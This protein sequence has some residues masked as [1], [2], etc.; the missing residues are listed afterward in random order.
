MAFNEVADRGGPHKTYRKQ[1][2]AAELPN[3]THLYASK[4]YVGEFQLPDHVEATKNPGALA[5]ATEAKSSIEAA[6]LP[7]QRTPKP[8]SF[9]TFFWCKASGSVERLSGVTV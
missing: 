3:L 7:K 2:V 1:E 8:I 9:A 5:G 6:K 4:A